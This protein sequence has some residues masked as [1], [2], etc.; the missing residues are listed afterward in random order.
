MGLEEKDARVMPLLY[1]SDASTKTTQA[2][3]SPSPVQKA[4]APAAVPSG[5]KRSS[6]A[7]L[8]VH[9]AKLLAS[10]KRRRQRG[11]ALSPS[12]A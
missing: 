2:L 8:H 10:G 9:A 11:G 5:T 1:A 7:P 12:V 4:V 6:A 3:A